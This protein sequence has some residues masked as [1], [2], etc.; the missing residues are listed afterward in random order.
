[1]RK[2]IIPMLVLIVILA[3]IMSIVVSSKSNYSRIPQYTTS[4]TKA[5]CTPENFCQDYLIF[6]ENKNLISMSPITGV[7]VQFQKDWYDPRT[8]EIK[9]KFC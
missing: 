4:E 7:V 3:T 9:N 6:C 8:P 1:M 2:L 5:I